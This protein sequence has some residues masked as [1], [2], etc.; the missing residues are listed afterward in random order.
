[1]M[2]LENILMSILTLVVHSHMCFLNISIHLSCNTAGKLWY[3]LKQWQ[4]FLI[5][6]VEVLHTYNKLC[7]AN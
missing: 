2:R 6:G 4:F 1:M 5:L 3:I 7:Y